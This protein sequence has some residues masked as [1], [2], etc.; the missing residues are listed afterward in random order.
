[1]FRKLFGG[2]SQKQ[3]PPKSVIVQVG[4]A[5]NYTVT[6][7]KGDASDAKL[8][9]TVGFLRQK[10]I[11]LLKANGKTLDTVT[12]IFSGKKLTNDKAALLDYG[13]TTGSKILVTIR[14]PPGSQ[15]AAASSSPSPSPAP[16]VQL[17]PR[18]KIQEA[19]DYVKREL[20][21]PINKFVKSPPK[22][23]D[24]RT[25][26]H[27]RLSEMVLQKMFALDDVDV[28]EDPDLRTFRKEA[29]NKFHNYHA[30]LDKAKKDS[31][32]AAASTSASAPA[33]NTSDATSQSSK[34][35]KKG[36]KS[37]K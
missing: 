31:D 5:T 13:V 32:E 3:D 11:E 25:D 19:L 20:E 33:D 14:K 28:S 34:K 37:K 9:P 36:K 29:I 26:Q 1:M 21:E 22:D 27:R 4:K 23:A 12:L 17:T 16:K 2:S 7:E 30:A 24:Q 6:F 15:P 18:E 8:G 35:K 10:V